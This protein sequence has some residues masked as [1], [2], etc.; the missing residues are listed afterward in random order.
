MQP[1]QRRQASSSLKAVLQG[2][3]KRRQ[4]E[5]GVLQSLQEEIAMGAGSRWLAIRILWCF[6]Y[7]DLY[8]I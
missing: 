6:S 5:P 7:G 8:M 2:L 3:Q 1:S 4:L